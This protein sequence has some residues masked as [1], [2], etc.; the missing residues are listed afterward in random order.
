MPHRMVVLYRSAD[1]TQQSEMCTKQIVQC[2][3]DLACVRYL[4]FITG[5]VNAPT[6]DWTNLV[7]LE[8]CSDMHLLDFT[9]DNGF[10]Q[11]VRDATRQN[12]ILD[13]ILTNDPNTVYDVRVCTPIGRSDHCGVNF[14]V[15]L[16]LDSLDSTLNIVHN[17]S[18]TARKCYRWSGANYD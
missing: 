16:E 10:T 9:I 3:E 12:S 13:V 5:D 11:M 14:T 4:C 15:V 7:M 18:H 2:L 6:I 1:T 8:N 17:T